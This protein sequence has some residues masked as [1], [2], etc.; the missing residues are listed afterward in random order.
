MSLRIVH[1]ITVQ[2]ADIAS[3]RVTPGLV[4]FQGDVT[5]FAEH[6]GEVTERNTL[7]NLVTFVGR[8]GET[9]YL[10]VVAELFECCCFSGHELR[11]FDSYSMAPIRVLC[12]R[13][14]TL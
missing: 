9:L 8:I 6:I 12:K 3:K 10:P 7:A 2:V 11:S 5:I 14:W 13:W 1:G 4:L